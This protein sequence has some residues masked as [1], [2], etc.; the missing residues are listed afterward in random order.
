MR[1]VRIGLVLAVV[2]S[3][4]TGCYHAVVDTGLE[5]E[6]AAVTH[7][8]WANSWIAGLIPPKPIDATDLCRGQNAA[9]VE[10]QHTFLNMLVDVLTAGIYTP[11]T[12]QVTCAA[13]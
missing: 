9:K 13:S 11:I 10:T 4:T 3:T 8:V 1:A 2:V 5:P 12:I 6:P 7:D